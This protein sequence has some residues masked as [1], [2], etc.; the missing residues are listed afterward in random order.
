MN[1]ITLSRGAAPYMAAISAWLGSLS[2]LMAASGKS[3]PSQKSSDASEQ[4]PPEKKNSSAPPP[5]PGSPTK[6]PEQSDLILSQ[7]PAFIWITDTALVVTRVMGG[8]VKP[9][10]YDPTNEVGSH[11]SDILKVDSESIVIK[12]HKAALRGQ[13]GKYIEHYAAR[14]YEVRVEPLRDADGEII[15][16]LGL[17]VDVTE[18]QQTQKMLR[19]VQRQLDRRAQEQNEQLK[20]EVD[21]RKRTE[22]QLRHSEELYRGIIE[23]QKDLVV[24]IDT[25]GRFTFANDA[26]C[27]KFGKEHSELIGSNFQPLVHPDDIERTLK[28]MEHLYHPPY[29]ASVEQRAQTVDGWRWIV[30]EDYAIRDDEGNIVEIQGVGR[31]ITEGILARENE[32]KQRAMAEAMRDIATAINSTL[33]LDEVLE[34]IL[35]NVGTVVEHDAANIMLLGE[36]EQ[37]YIV[38]SRGYDMY[39]LEEVVTKTPIFVRTFPSF[40]HMI[41]TKEPFLVNDTMINEQWIDVLK[42]NW[43]RSYAGAPIIIEG[44]LLGFLNLDSTHPNAFTLD[45]TDRLKAFTEHAAIAIRN[46]RLYEQAQELAAIEAAMEERQ[47][48]SRE[49][50]DAVSQ[51]IF[52]AS[53]IAQSLARVSDLNQEDVRADLNEINNLTRSALAEMRSLL[54]ELRPMDLVDVK[55]EDLLTQLVDAFRG[56]SKIKIAL[57]I[58]ENYPLTPEVRI[59]LYRITQEA[60]NNILKHAHAQ[61]ASISL[62]NLENTVKL[63]ITDD[64]RGFDPNTVGPSHLGL[65]I[66]RERA[67]L[68]GAVLT[69]D[70][71]PDKGTEI[72]VKWVDSRRS[73]KEET[74]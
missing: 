23:S 62:H 63:R 34:R 30:W 35:A 50:H 10:T 70:S 27:R 72:A 29:R 4:A 68:I 33:D 24:R 74:S 57:N 8:N 43:F 47:R 2:I 16:C 51:S 67:E 64:G 41:H 44:E 48:I 15:G 54:L 69:I 28:E 14:E 59:A 6:P 73:D 11:L 22:A 18:Q 21:E 17:A 42:L 45:D 13:S 53:V 55:L 65:G 12:T 36:N 37:F 56:K 26:Y 61:H 38:R 58:E 60:L 25:E 46:A 40:Q 32:R 66:M 71:Q 9:P 3:E 39:D 19:H 5:H 31:D 1:L 52:S 49:L 20:R 7:L